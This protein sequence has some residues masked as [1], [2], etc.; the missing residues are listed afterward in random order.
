MDEKINSFSLST[1]IVSLCTS[2]FYG[3]FSSYIINTSN[4]SSLI[5]LVIGFVLSLLL[6][7]III[8][9][10]KSNEDLNYNSKIK[11]LFP[12][13]SILINIVSIMCSIFGYM[14]ITYRLTT[15]LSNE[16]LIETPRFMISI[17]ILCLTY[18][19]SSKGF[20]TIIRVSLIT[21]FISIFIFLFDAFSLI[22][23]IKFDNYLP[24]IN[25][26]FKNIIISSLVFA[27]YFTLPLI[28]INII[29]FNKIIDK[30]KFS[31]YYY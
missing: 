29:P 16:Y 17:L 14:L 11:K 9:F 21:F 15:F 6:S 28:Y 19:S 27:M 30:N 24:I 2:T 25:V 31:K 22:P 5:S 7:K 10:F 13:A 26:P 23:Q 20:N 18:Y 3:V 4:N 1:I 8:S 12:K